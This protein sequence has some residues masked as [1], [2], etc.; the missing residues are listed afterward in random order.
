MFFGFEYFAGAN[1]VIEIKGIP[2]LE[3]AG[4]SY[5]VTESK[6]PI[7][8]YSSRF[9][10]GVARGQVLV[11][12]QLLFN[13]VHEDYVR[14]VLST[15]ASGPIVTPTAAELRALAG[16]SVKSDFGLNP[17][18]KDLLTEVATRYQDEASVAASLKSLYWPSTGS[19]KSSWN[20]HD[21][22][23]GFNIR[24]TFGEKD[25]MTGAGRTGVE[26]ESVYIVGRGKQIQISEDVIVESFPFFARNTS[27]VYPKTRLWIEENGDDL[28]ITSSASDPGIDAR[29]SASTP[30]GGTVDP[31]LN[32]A[33]WSDPRATLYQR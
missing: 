30:Q 26:I 18:N 10:D 24:A 13:Y 17:K 1:V 31:L 21:I 6:R 25:L 27:A 32:K 9:F 14:E 7:Y 5:E 33:S 19:S 8:G 23:G 12:G 11:Q 16:N 20:P 29:V 28:T 3:C 2:A 15:S 22:F 4:I